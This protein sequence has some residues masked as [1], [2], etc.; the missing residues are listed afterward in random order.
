MG[1]NKGFGLEWLACGCLR[2]ISKKV[3]ELNMIELRIYDHGR[4]SAHRLSMN[5]ASPLCRVG[6][7][8]WNG[9]EMNRR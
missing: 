6:V 8:F 5:V 4:R 7:S 2:R 9:D 1:I 3:P